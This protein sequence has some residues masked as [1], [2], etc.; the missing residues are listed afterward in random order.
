MGG[1]FT[2]AI[3]ISERGM[4][5]LI[6]DVMNGSG[7]LPGVATDYDREHHVD[8]VHLNAFLN[9]TQPEVAAQL[10]LDS[11]T[12]TRH[13]FLERL[14]R[15]VA[16]RG[17]ID[18]LRNGVGHLQHNINLFYPK[19]TPGNE[20]AAF[21]HQR[22]RFSI[23]RQLRYSSRNRNLSLDLALFVN[24]LPIITM[25]L[26]NNLTGQTYKHA[27]EQY[28]TD[29]SPTR[30][31]LFRPGR[32]AAHFALDESQVHFCA[33]LAGKKQLVCISTFQQG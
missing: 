17:V 16:R 12:R 29:R 15:E 23:T 30:E 8:L 25:E 11:D 6:F 27:I 9:A 18:A 4:E 28:Q 7:W 24:G 1:E 13:R 10:S 31:P 26:K 3:D 14:S 19:P 32:C 5:T 33:E 20:T 2:H 22:N 21:L